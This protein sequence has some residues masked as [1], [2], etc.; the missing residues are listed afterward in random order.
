[1]V[2]PLFRLINPSIVCSLILLPL[3]PFS[4]QP[5]SAFPTNT[6]VR[7]P[8]TCPAAARPG[9]IVDDPLAFPA[10]GT[11]VAEVDG[12]PVCS[13]GKDFQ[14]WFDTEF[15]YEYQCVQFVQWYFAN[16]WGIRPRW[17]VNYA[18]EMSKPNKIPPGVRLFKNGTSPG[19]TRGDALVFDQTEVFP[20]GHVAIVTDVTGG[21]VYIAE[22]NFQI[23]LQ[24]SWGQ[25]WLEIDANNTIS[26]TGRPP[27][28]GW[29]H[30]EKNQGIQP[31]PG[32]L[33]IELALPGI[34]NLPGD[35]NQPLHPSR[36]VQLEL[37][38]PSNRLVFKG[39]GV[40]NYDN[41]KGVFKG[42]IDL[43]DIP[44][45]LYKVKIWMQNSLRAI[46]PG[47]YSTNLNVIGRGVTTYLQV[48]MQRKG[49]TTRGGLIWGFALNTADINGDNQ[50][51]KADYNDLL[52]CMNMTGCEVGSP[53]HISSDINDDGG[54]DLLDVQIWQR[55]SDLPRAGG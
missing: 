25:G 11:Q 48:G 54:A 6:D 7:L 5:P 23:N 14:N 51:D 37:F 8:S 52:T 39:N 32:M 24:A 43:G 31:G 1:M 55:L 18:F 42:L 19:P 17:G 9:S 29:L 27:V 35:N 36:R 46:L 49:I 20:G 30:A 44:S 50:V 13:N 45:G 3:S 12:V 34:S 38:D 15:G 10:W 4:K 26:A 33:G 22:Q 40:F 28:I 53:Q 21:K 47:P 2:V 16:R 41:T